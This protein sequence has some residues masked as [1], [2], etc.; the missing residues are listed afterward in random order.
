MTNL[1]QKFEEQQVA[2]LSENKDIP[3][4]RPGD[5][6]RVKVRIVEGTTER[7]QA[8]EGLC[9][10]RKNAGL[11]SSYTVRKISHGE[12]VERVFPLYSPRIAGIE[13]VRRGIVRRAKL[14]YMRALTGKAARIREKMDFSSGK[15][16]KAAKAAAAEKAAPKEK[17][18]AKKADKE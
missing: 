3:D 6:V 7:V 10:A 4:F 18:E 14:Y 12:G 13:L 16:A 17:A 11:N 2:R 1:L 5:V 9:I 8:F 15:A